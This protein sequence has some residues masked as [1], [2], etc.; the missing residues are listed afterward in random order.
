MDEFEKIKKELAQLY[1][2]YRIQFRN[3]AYLEHQLDEHTRDEH[4]R[5]QVTE[6]S[7]KMMQTQIQEEELRVLKNEDSGMTYLVFFNLNN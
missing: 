1:Q 3:L 7:F 5:V 4:E 6:N 2:N